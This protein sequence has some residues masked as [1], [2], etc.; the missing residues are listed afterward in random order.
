MSKKQLCFLVSAVAVVL[1]IG[2]AVYLHSRSGSSPADISY[3]ARI[4]IQ[5][6]STESCNILPQEKPSDSCY[7]GWNSGEDSC[8]K[9]DG[10]VYPRDECLL[11]YLQ[12]F[13]DR[14]VCDTLY[15]LENQRS[16]YD[17]VDGGGETSDLEEALLQSN[18]LRYTSP[19][20]F[21]FSYPK[22]W[23]VD[24]TDV[25]HVLLISPQLKKL[26]QDEP[27]TSSLGYD[28]SVSVFGPNSDV[29]SEVASSSLDTYLAHESGSGASVR[30]VRFAN[31]DA[32]DL[33]SGEYYETQATG[34]SGARDIWY[35]R[36]GNVYRV[37]NVRSASTDD[38][39][40]DGILTSF[41]LN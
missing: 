31:W 35:Q 18:W 37:E 13:K 10:N 40:Q 27:R 17:L 32:L 23:T 9:G 15:A 39:F 26:M 5:E 6:K 29:G 3:D 28:L 24:D 19:E 4:A 12:T 36:L 30:Q 22:D 41:W 2:V 33:F 8:G 38:A 11:T 21:S 7:S 20:R 16:C 1:C 25:D 14:R 34:T